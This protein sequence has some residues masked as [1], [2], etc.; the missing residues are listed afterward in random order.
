MSTLLSELDSIMDQVSSRKLTA[1]T[2]VQWIERLDCLCRKALLINNFHF[3]KQAE[4]VSH[5]LYDKIL[6]S[7]STANLDTICMMLDRF[8]AD[9]EVI[10]NAIEDC[11]LCKSPADKNTLITL[12]VDNVIRFEKH[13]SAVL[14]RLCEAI[15]YH[16]TNCNNL[17]RLLTAVSD[18]VERDFHGPIAII[19]VAIVF[20][21][22]RHKYSECTEKL[23][24]LKAWIKDNELSLSETITNQPVN[25]E[26]TSLAI[27]F[28]KN[29]EY[30]HLYRA[31]LLRKDSIDYD[32]FIEAYLINE[33]LPDAGQV[34]YILSD[35]D[36][37]NKSMSSLIAI[38][39]WMSDIFPS[40]EIRCTRSMTVQL[41]EA[42]KFVPDKF[43]KDD[44]A[45]STLSKVFGIP[46]TRL[47]LDDL[48]RRP[49]LARVLEKIPSYNVQRLE[50]S[51]GL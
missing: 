1:E 16:D 46:N 50:S 44:F 43:I 27:K 6:S 15:A 35:I 7:K 10:S 8:P 26:I 14:S 28:A 34:T 38:G 13:S 31:L 17:L 5:K 3:A 41:E 25:P 11:R 18:R 22:D 32:E 9:A 36:L 19:R 33:M 47:L 29:N 20:Q 48:H 39:L 12:A 51:L 45:H 21:R 2:A 4:R 37:I 42:I 40:D 49:N 30:H 24:A 23:I